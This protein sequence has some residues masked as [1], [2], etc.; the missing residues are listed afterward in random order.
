MVKAIRLHLRM[1]NCL[2]NGPVIK[3]NDG[4]ELQRFS[5]QLTSCAN[6]LK[7]I[8]CI[9]KLDNS[10]NLK[11]IINCLPTAIQYKWRDAVDRI[12]EQE[13]RDIT[14]NDVMKFVASRARA[15]NYPVFG[16][17]GR[18]RKENIDPDQR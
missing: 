9:G 8:G 12:V 3:P 10:K 1:L 2:I 6:T 13:R 4:V 18:E 15:A 14:I 5:I 16:K 11:R 7:E 17:V